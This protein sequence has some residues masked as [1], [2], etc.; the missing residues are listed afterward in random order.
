MVP[1]R[2][3]GIWRRDWIERYPGGEARPVRDTRPAVWFQS[4]R[5]HVDLRIDDAPAVPASPGTAPP[6]TQIAF[7][8]RTEVRP[9]DGREICQWWPAFAYPQPTG[10]VD[11]GFITFESATHMM[12]EGVDGRYVESWRRIN[13]DDEP[14][15]CL[16]FEAAHERA[17]NCYLMLCGR[18]FAFGSNIGH[19]EC[20]NL[21][22]YA[23]GQRVDGDSVWRVLECLAPWC[24]SRDRS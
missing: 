6:T 11:A 10:D 14:P 12:E 19:P 1:E 7:A 23:W 5:F 9:Q 3:I 13:H 2:Y 17:A 4:S 22:V 15:R 20:P 24:W 16:R 21:P 8:G 18:H